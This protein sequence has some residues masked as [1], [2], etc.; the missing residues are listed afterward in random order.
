MNSELQAAYKR[1]CENHGEYNSDI[2]EH[3]P[4]LRKYAEKCEHITEFGVRWVVSTWALIAGAPKK[5]VSYDI[6]KYL[7][8]ERAKRVAIE[9]GV[10]FTFVLG[11]TLEVDIEETDLLF[12]DTLHTYAQL[13]G[14]LER[15]AN[16]ARKYI[17]M[18]DTVAYALRGMGPELGG[19]TIQKGLKNAIDEFLEADKNW[20]VKE[21]FNNNN[22]LTVLA[23]KQ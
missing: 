23:R 6:E 2:Y 3:V 14:E 21:V 1:C 22:G 7:D 4:T 12:I 11:S 15:H 20:V 18:H 16:K 19:D 13:K 10:D 5:M 8:V 9:N 17:I